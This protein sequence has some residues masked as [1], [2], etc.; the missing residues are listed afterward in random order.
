MKQPEIITP[1]HGILTK[2]LAVLLLTAFALPAQAQTN[3]WPVM[4]AEVYMHPVRGHVSM[5]VLAKQGGMEHKI[6]SGSFDIYYEITCQN[7]SC[8]AD[9]PRT[10]KR[11]YTTIPCGISESG[12]V[13]YNLRHLPSFPGIAGTGMTT[14][15]L[16]ITRIEYDDWTDQHVD[17]INRRYGWTHEVN[18]K[19]EIVRVAKIR[20]KKEGYGSG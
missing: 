3:L 15:T 19:G 18:E 16:D 14:F 9:V 1:P 11:G 6:Q 13:V 20:C 2:L 4:E 7:G 12:P 10:V 5:R 17:E 8:P